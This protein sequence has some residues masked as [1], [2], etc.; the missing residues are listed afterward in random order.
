[1]IAKARIYHNLHFKGFRRVTKG[2]P[3]LPKIFN[4]VVDTVMH[5]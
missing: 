2:N 4:V 1:M 5:H 3:L